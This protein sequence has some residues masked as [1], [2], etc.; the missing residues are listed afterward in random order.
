M[1]YYI[2]LATIDI[3]LFLADK[4]KELTFTA[5]ATGVGV[6]FG[7]RIGS[8]IVF[9]QFIRRLGLEKKSELEQQVA[10]LIE[11][12]RG[13]GNI[14]S[15]SIS[16]PYRLNINRLLL[17]RSIWSRMVRS[18]AR[19][20]KLHMRWR[21]KRMSKFKSRKFWMSVISALL[22][23]ANEG[24]ELGISSETVMTFAALIA[25]FIFSEA[26]I[27][28]KRAKEDVNIGDSGPAE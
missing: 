9:N 12:E 1:W 22:V 6:I 11:L 26:Y 4:W 3:G 21:K 2:F 17:K 23:I 24:L 20:T 16:K 10:W 19:Y 8:R 5:V 28:G 13:R 15:A 18:I 14:W 25:S 7:K 27:D